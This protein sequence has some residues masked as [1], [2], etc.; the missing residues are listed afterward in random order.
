MIDIYK[1]IGKHGHSYELDDLVK[2][3]ANCPASE[4]NGSGPGSCGG[5]K[6]AS[7]THSKAGFKHTKF[8]NSD[9]RINEIQDNV[10]EAFSIKD[11]SGEKLSEHSKKVSNEINKVRSE[12]K[13]LTY[14]KGPNR[15][16]AIFTK[17]VQ[18]EKLSQIQDDIDKKLKSK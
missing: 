1:F 4:K 6:D 9:N 2:S 12:I 15:E 14:G 11:I 5:S 7:D 3:N 17:S 18:L 10:E 16:E 8:D 13:K